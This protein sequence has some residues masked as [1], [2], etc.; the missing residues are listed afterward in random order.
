MEYKV[1]K[2][3]PV[4]DGVVKVG[5]KVWWHC[6]EGPMHLRVEEGDCNIADYPQYYSINKPVFVQHPEVD[7]L[8]IYEHEEAYKHMQ[9]GHKVLKIKHE[10]KRPE[11]AFEDGIAL[12]N[13]TL[14]YCTPYSKKL[15]QLDKRFVSDL[16][17]VLAEEPINEEQTR[18]VI[19]EIGKFLRVTRVFQQ[20]YK[21]KELRKKLKLYIKWLQ[22]QSSVIQS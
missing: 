9:K 13:F 16:I 1:V 18:F 17:V 7:W 6:E 20:S 11:F 14:K 19:S 8:V 21:D 4:R 3:F 12:H 15:V 22:S 10:R 5:E 2:T